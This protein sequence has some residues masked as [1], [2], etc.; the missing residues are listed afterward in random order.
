MARLQELLTASLALGF[1]SHPYHE[2]LAGR[3]IKKKNDWDPRLKPTHPWIQTVSKFLEKGL[4]MQRNTSLMSFGCHTSSPRSSSS[5]GLSMR[6]GCQILK[7]RRS[8]QFLVCWQSGIRT[9]YLSCTRLGQ[10]NL[11][12]KAKSRFSTPTSPLPRT[13]RLAIEGGEMLMSAK[14]LGPA[15]AYQLVLRSAASLCRQERGSRYQLQIGQTSIT[16]C[17]A[18]LKGPGATC[19]GPRW[20]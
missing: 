17:P 20:S 19:F 12:Q 4:G 6:G 3:K 13:G 7:L 10:F 16:R 1:S 2:E 15:R 14:F 11:A 9:T 18:H 5:I 8:I